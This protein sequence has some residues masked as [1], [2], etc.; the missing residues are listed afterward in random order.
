MDCPQNYYCYMVPQWPPEQTGLAIGL[1]LAGLGVLI[2]F[3]AIAYYLF[4]RVK[5]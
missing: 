2:L 4:T 5:G 1:G 3:S